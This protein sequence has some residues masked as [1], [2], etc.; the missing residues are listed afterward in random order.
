MPS[1]KVTY[2]NGRGRG[3]LVRMCLSYAGQEFED[4][5]LDGGWDELRKTMMPPYLPVLEVDGV[6]LHETCLIAQYIACKHGF[7]GESE[8]DKI[9]VSS[10]TFYVESLFAAGGKIFRE[11]NE[12]RKK[13]LKT[14]FDDKTLPDFLERMEGIVSKNDAGVLYGKSITQADIHFYV[15]TSM[16]KQ[17]NPAVLEKTPALQALFTKVETSPKIA[18]WV[19]K[20]PETAW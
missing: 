10:Y 13:E 3:E 7:G 17:G 12:E 2:F 9:I 5:R 20:R 4:K 8:E 6:S 19:A 14:V 15:T 16:F 1:Y 11:S 18:E